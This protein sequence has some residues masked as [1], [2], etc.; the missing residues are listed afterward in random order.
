MFVALAFFLYLT[1]LE[2][3]TDSNGFAYHT[4]LK[5]LFV[6]QNKN[7]NYFKQSNLT[8]KKLTN[9]YLHIL[10]LT[11]FNKK[12]NKSN[13]SMITVS[14]KTLSVVPKLKQTS[15]LIQQTIQTP[16]FIKYYCYEQD[17]RIIKQTKPIKLK[18]SFFKL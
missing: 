18:I 16:Y 3:S 9:S 11:I 10:L 5:Y 1:T 13:E 7:T 17:D 15:Y 8:H 14:Q 6:C 2:L 4:N 12:T